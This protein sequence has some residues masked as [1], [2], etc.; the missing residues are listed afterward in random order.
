M[1][2]GANMILG[3]GPTG[4]GIGIASKLPILEAESFAGGICRSFFLDRNGSKLNS[5]DLTDNAYRFENGGGHWLFGLTASTRA[6]LENY[7]DL[8]TYHREAAV[9]FAHKQHFTPYPIQNHCELLPTEPNNTSLKSNRLIVAEG[10]LHEWMLQRFGT[11]LCDLF[12]FP[13]HERYTCGLYRLVAPQDPAKSPVASTS[14]AAAGYNQTFAYPVEGLSVLFDRIANECDVRYNCKV[15]S[16]DCH[17]RCLYLS[18]GRAIRY[19]KLFSTL[20]LNLMARLT[21]MSTIEREDPAVSVVVV[22]IGATRG[23]RCPRQHWIYVPESKSGFHRIG[24]YSNINARFLPY[25]VSELDSHVSLYV[26]TSFE[27]GSA[28]A[29]TFDPNPIV[30]ELIDWEFIDQVEALDVSYVNVGYTWSWPQS[31]WR[32]I[33]ISKLKECGIIQCGRYGRWQFQGIVESLSEGL[34]IGRDWI[35]SQRSG[36]EC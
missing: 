16:I 7:V 14:G 32:Q 24:F 25:S 5:S 13:F 30:Q 27:S 8:E 4:L 21:G 29:L 36:H 33:C 28:S 3:A 9:Y 22:N 6:F 15:T 18:D 12:F 11:T 34:T 35:N 26:E 10:T 17:D 31:Q 19:L 2:F 20:P 1:T 23:R